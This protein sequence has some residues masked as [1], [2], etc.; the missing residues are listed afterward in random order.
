[1]C[2]KIRTRPFDLAIDLLIEV[3]DGAGTDLCT[4]Q[5]F[6]DVLHPPDR[7]AGQIHLNQSLLHG[8]LLGLIAPDDLRFEGQTPKP[9]NFQI[10]LARLGEQLSVTAS[11]PGVQ[12]LRCPLIAA[13]IADGIR[14]RIQQGVQC[15]LDGLP[16]QTVN[17]V[18]N[19]FF[20]NFDG[21]GDCFFRFMRYIFHDLFSF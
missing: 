8:A 20:I 1:M 15:V 5:R 16:H 12:P 11:R 7:N 10:D 18:L 9:G 14:F 21:S 2:A 6:R 17:V 13:R 3:T 4:P 19:L